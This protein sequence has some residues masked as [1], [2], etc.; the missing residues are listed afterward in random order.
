MQL[1]Y[2]HNRKAL[3][4]LIYVIPVKYIREHGID[5]NGPGSRGESRAYKDKTYQTRAVDGKLNDSMGTFY[6][7]G[8]LPATGILCIDVNTAGQGSGFTLWN[9][10]H[11][12]EPNDIIIRAGQGKVAQIGE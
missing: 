10:Q 12:M 2:T 5:P 7:T 11:G 8:E 4:N 1:I 9:D 6:I 3:E